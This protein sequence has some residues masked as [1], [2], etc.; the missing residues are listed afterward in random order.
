MFQHQ[1]QQEVLVCPDCGG[2]LSPERELL[3]CN[4]HGAFFIYGSQ[5]LV[6]APRPAGKPAEPPMPWESGRTRVA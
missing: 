6:R 2:K 4:E 5:L 3:I 1:M